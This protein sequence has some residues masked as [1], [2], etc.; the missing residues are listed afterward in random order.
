[1]IRVEVDAVDFT[2]TIALCDTEA[3][4]S[5]AY[6]LADVDA[7]ALDGSSIFRI[8]NLQNQPAAHPSRIE[9]MQ[10][11]WREPNAHIAVSIRHE[12][13]S[14]T[15]LRHLRGA[16]SLARFAPGAVYRSWFVCM[17]DEPCLDVGGSRNS[18][19]LGFSVF[20]FVAEGFDHLRSLFDMNARAPEY[21]TAPI[22]LRTV[23]RIAD[24][25]ML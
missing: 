4:V 21:L 7:G 22:P 11:G 20:G 13:T 23:R 6:F 25:T 1:L 8:V 16:V 17:R 2:F 10:M 24:A 12:P 19:G 5:C 18:D 3:P 9:V 15:G 14:E